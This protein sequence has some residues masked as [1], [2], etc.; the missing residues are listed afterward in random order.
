MGVAEAQIKKIIHCIKIVIITAKVH[1]AKIA[2]LVTGIAAI[3][4]RL[5]LQ[6]STSQGRLN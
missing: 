4:H 3:L 1:Q 6:Q 2:E 5:S